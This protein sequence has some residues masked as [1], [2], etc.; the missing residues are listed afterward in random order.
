[1]QEGIV[2]WFNDGKGFGFIA[3]QGKD[4]FV[5][6]KEIQKDGFKSLK[7]GEKVKFI[8]GTS[9]KGP[10]ATKVTVD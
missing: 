1:M 10:I 3:S 7:Q 4:Y 9:A 6:F 5:Y 2:K 8:A